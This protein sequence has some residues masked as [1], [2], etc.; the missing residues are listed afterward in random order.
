LHQVID[1]VTSLGS[2]PGLWLLLLLLLAVFV[3]V[4]ALYAFDDEIPK[5]RWLPF[6]VIGLAAGLLIAGG[7]SASALSPPNGSAPLIAVTAG[8]IGEVVAGGVVLVGGFSYFQANLRRK[9]REVDLGKRLEVVARLLDEGLTGPRE[10]LAAVYQRAYLTR[11]RMLGPN[12]RE[13]VAEDGKTLRRGTISWLVPPVGFVNAPA[14]FSGATTQ[15]DDR[16]PED[17]TWHEKLRRAV[18]GKAWEEFRNERALLPQLRMQ[19]RASSR[20][21]ESAFQLALSDSDTFELSATIRR[22]E[23]DIDELA[24]CLGQLLQQ[25][26]R[27]YGGD[28]AATRLEQL[29]ATDDDGTWISKDLSDFIT[30]L[31][32]TETSLLEAIDKMERSL[33]RVPPHVRQ[34]LSSDGQGRQWGPTVKL[35][36]D[37]EEERARGAE[38]VNV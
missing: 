7:Y 10:L 15:E 29:Y 23:L 30:A 13:V 22:V 24:R 17:L 20:Y 35:L 26:Q 38:L 25:L 18:L 6:T 12:E 32:A 19:L 31:A 4:S 2:S 11:N 36:R 37:L 3:T 5:G 9:R 16:K 28:V 1:R 27:E 21:L 8:A 34:Q 33:D 14:R